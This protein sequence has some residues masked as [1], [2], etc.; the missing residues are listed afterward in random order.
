MTWRLI[1]APWAE[2][3]R[4]YTYFL[5]PD[6][7]D[8]SPGDVVLVEGPKGQPKFLI[9]AEV[10]DMEPLEFPAKSIAN[11]WPKAD[12]DAAKEEGLGLSMHEDY[13]KWQ[14]AAG[15]LNNGASAKYSEAWVR[16]E[17]EQR[18]ASQLDHHRCSM[19]DY[20]TRYLFRCGLVHFDAGC[21]CSQSSS[22]RDSSYE[23]IADWLAMQSSDEIRDDIWK[24][25]RT[26]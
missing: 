7:P 13:P 20:M 3:G 23:A 9:L 14:V 22:I 19:C 5:P 10:K 6:F 8:A 11:C 1:L 12:Y 2:G 25:L 26:A 16:F 21:D 18:G 4:L 15:L 24:G 17:V